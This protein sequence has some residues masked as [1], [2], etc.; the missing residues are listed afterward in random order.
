MNPI[1]M[2]S[3]EELAIITYTRIDDVLKSE[4]I[5]FIKNAVIQVAS[6]F[7][8]VH[9]DCILLATNY[10]WAINNKLFPNDMKINAGLK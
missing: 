8:D 2:I 3:P 5:K 1:E 7:D 10:I 4:D 6:D 9:T